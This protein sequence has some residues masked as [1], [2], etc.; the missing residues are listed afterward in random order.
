MLSSK[1]CR[2][3]WRSMHTQS[4]YK[5]PNRRNITRWSRMLCLMS[6]LLLLKGINRRLAARICWQPSTSFCRHCSWSTLSLDGLSER[7]RTSYIP[8]GMME[9]KFGITLLLLPVAVA[10]VLRVLLYF[11][12]PKQSQ[13]EPPLV[14]SFI[15]YV[16]HIIGMG[17][18][19]MRLPGTLRGF[20]C[21]TLSVWK[22][23]N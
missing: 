11:Y 19:T 6:R 10:I 15:P 18:S 5:R 3:R 21:L 12:T 16:G 2:S 8:N 7:D 13:N 17:K 9:I 1:L 22:Q 4:C 23:A 20:S 14:S